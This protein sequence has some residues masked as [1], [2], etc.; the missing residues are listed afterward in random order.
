VA[1]IYRLEIEEGELPDKLLAGDPEVPEQL[2][3]RNRGNV[4]WGRGARLHILAW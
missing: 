3:P 2:H 4:A 1:A